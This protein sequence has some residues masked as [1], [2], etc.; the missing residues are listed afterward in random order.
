MVEKQ[1][2]SS[3]YPC[4]LGGQWRGGKCTAVYCWT[5]LGEVFHCHRLGRRQKRKSLFR[6]FDVLTLPS[7][8]ESLGMSLIE[9]MSYG[10]LVIS[11]DAGSIP[12]AVDDGK[13]GFLIRTCR[14]RCAGWK[15]PV[16]FEERQTSYGDGKE[17]KATC[18]KGIQPNRFLSTLHSIYDELISHP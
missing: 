1:H 13:D 2:E 12:N 16:A 18:C 5:G 17:R 10:L 11:T 8:A 6:R 3:S 7:Y 14:Y 9:G 15:D 4:D